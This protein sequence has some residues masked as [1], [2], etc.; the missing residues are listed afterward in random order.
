MSL[1]HTSESQMIN[2]FSFC[3]DGGIDPRKHGKIKTLFFFLSHL[4]LTVALALS[5][6]LTSSM[7]LCLP[8]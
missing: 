6:C 3:R 1:V 8:S 4:A 7:L 5:T 2:T